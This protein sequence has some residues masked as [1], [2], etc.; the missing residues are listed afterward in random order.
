MHIGNIIILKYE[1][2][3]VIIINIKISK[4]KKYVILQEV[5]ILYL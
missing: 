2:L 1:I 3:F 4:G 5:N